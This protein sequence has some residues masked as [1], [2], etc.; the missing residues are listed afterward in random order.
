MARGWASPAVLTVVA[1]S[2]MQATATPWVVVSIAVRRIV[3]LSASLLWIVAGVAALGAMLLVVLLVVAGLGVVLLGL[4]SVIHAILGEL[5]APASAGI[6]IGILLVTIMLGLAL[7]HGVLRELRM[8][9]PVL[10]LA[11]LHGVLWELL[12]VPVSTLAITAL[13]TPVIAA[14]VVATLAMTIAAT[15]ATLWPAAATASV[16]PRRVARQHG[17]PARAPTRRTRR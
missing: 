14:L 1:L 2:R 17:E 15:V 6:L 8:P 16:A 7:L 11:S 5:L 13:I 12:L 4:P 9:T 3:I 10:G